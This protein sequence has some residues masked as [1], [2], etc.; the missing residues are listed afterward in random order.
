MKNYRNLK[1]N[2]DRVLVNFVK[3]VLRILG[4][5]QIQDLQPI[6]FSVICQYLMAIHLPQK[7]CVFALGYEIPQKF[8]YLLKFYMQ[9]N[10]LKSIGSQSS[11][12][13]GITIP[14]KLHIS[15]LPS[16]SQETKWSFFHINSPSFL[17]GKI[18]CD[19]S[20]NTLKT[21]CKSHSI[22]L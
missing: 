14:S 4:E 20:Q 17:E 11:H 18:H 19:R 8:H 16:A 7:R 9:H 2:H 15:C 13:N 1:Y 21:P 3:E 22:D 10:E 12:K 5:I 6:W